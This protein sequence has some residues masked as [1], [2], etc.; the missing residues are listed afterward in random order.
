VH[1]LTRNS[2]KGREIG[3]TGVRCEPSLSV[4]DGNQADAS[5]GPNRLH[6]SNPLLHGAEYGWDG[7]G[8]V[9]TCPEAALYRLSAAARIDSQQSIIKK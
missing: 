7:E 3:N 6:S 4:G 9:E 5:L 1:C 8:A 2:R